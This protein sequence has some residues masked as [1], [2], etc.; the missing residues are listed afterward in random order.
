MWI[1]LSGGAGC[2]LICA[3]QAELRIASVEVLAE[4]RLAGVLAYSEVVSGRVEVVRLLG[5]EA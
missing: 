1:L 3:G 4:Y 2:T 5:R